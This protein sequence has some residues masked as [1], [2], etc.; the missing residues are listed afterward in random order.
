MDKNNL[1]ELAKD[2]YHLTLL[3]PAKEPLRYKLRETADDIVAEYIMEKNDYLSDIRR[4]FEVIYSYLD[5][6]VG[7]NW[8]SPARIN[9]IRDNYALAAQKLTEIK[10][11]QEIAANNKI[12]EAEMASVNEKIAS[13]TDFILIPDQPKTEMTMPAAQNLMEP[14]V[15]AAPAIAVAAEDE[16]IGEPAEKFKTSAQRIAPSD[17]ET[18]DIGEEGPIGKEGNGL[19]NG[20]VVRQNRIVEFLKQHGSAQVWEIQKIFPSVSKRTIRRDFRS[21]L[22]QGLIERTGE[23]NTTAYKLKITLS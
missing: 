8:V 5:I 12:R 23:R 4:L 16:E 2:V 17:L 21:M 22:K 1:T 7:Q 9:Q 10:L 11:A 14:P 15:Q 13:G 3:F 6:A 19:S 20:Q 18:E